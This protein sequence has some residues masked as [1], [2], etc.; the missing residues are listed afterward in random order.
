MMLTLK[1]ILAAIAVGGVAWR[2]R[3][4]WP[5]VIAAASAAIAV[6]LGVAPFSSLGRALMLTMPMLVF[7]S[8]ALTLAALAE[9][10]GLCERAAAS[11]SRAA[12]GRTGVLFL[13]TCLLCALLTS[14]V[15][16]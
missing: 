11:L 9:R 15:S 8:A 4:R 12:R 5:A 10:S 2:P 7:L 1:L 6:A 14:V 13:L 3:R 16:L